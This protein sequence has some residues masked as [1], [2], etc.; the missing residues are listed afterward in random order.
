MQLLFAALAFLTILPWPAGEISP[1][2]LPTIGVFFP[3]VGWGVG[4]CLA[5]AGWLLLLLGL[6]PLPA[7]A[8]LVALSAWLTRGLHL[9]GVADLFDGLGGGADPAKRLAIMKDSATGAFGVIGLVLVLLLKTTALADLLAG[10]KQENGSPLIF[11]LFCLSSVPALG[12][13]TILL[14]SWRSRYPR[15]QGTG[16]AFVGKIRG[17]HLL[18]GAVF[19]APLLGAVGLETEFLLPV[20][21]CCTAAFVPVLLLRWKCRKLLG[22]IT[23]DV[24]GAGCEFSEVLGWIVLGLFF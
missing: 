23:G 18:L 5:T 11:V 12:R 6:S 24:L 15:Q 4:I 16:H 14:L 19:L 13:F 21:L 2:R 20:V 3:L 10:I 1:Q 7:A 17:R 9:D 22:G 8:L